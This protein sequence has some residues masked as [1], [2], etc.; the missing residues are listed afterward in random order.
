[1]E[2]FG[3]TSQRERKILKYFCLIDDTPNN[4]R[5]IDHRSDCNI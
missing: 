4:L 5:C 2:V 3:C 1:L